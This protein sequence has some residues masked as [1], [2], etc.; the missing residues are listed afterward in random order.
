[1]TEFHLMFTGADNHLAG[2][3]ATPI[4]LLNERWSSVW[5]WP[6]NTHLQLAFLQ[7]TA[8]YKPTEDFSVQSVGYFRGFRQA[9]VDGNG[10][11]AQPCAAAGFLCIG[12]PFTPI[13]QNFPVPDTLS[14]GAFLGE[15]DRNWTSTASYG[16]SVQATSATKLFGHDNHLVVGMSIDHGRTQ[17]SGTSELGTV[18]PNLFVAGTGIFID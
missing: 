15:I 5:T 18:E 13:N 7:G 17:F 2:T 8:S 4:E 9:H 14:P 16:G 6:Q 3:V 10:T 12:D 11:D 1:E